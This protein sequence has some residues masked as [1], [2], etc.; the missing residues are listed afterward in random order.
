MKIK[1]IMQINKVQNFN[2]WIINK[3]TKYMRSRDPIY[4]LPE[5]FSMQINGDQDD[6]SSYKS[7]S[8]KRNRVE[9]PR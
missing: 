1:K 9:Q 5:G 8:L 3:I 2:V 7:Y 4:P 6:V